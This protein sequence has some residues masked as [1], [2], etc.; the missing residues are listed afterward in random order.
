MRTR[1]SY[2]TFYLCIW[3]VIVLN[4]LED[5]RYNLVIN[6]NGNYNE[7]LFF[8][9][10][11][12]A[13][14]SSSTEGSSIHHNRRNN[15]QRGHGQRGNHGHGHNNNNNNFLYN[16]SSGIYILQP[17]PEMQEVPL[18][19]GDIAMPFKSYFA[20][21]GAPTD[22][23]RWNQALMQAARGEQVLLSRVMNVIKSPLDLFE[24]DKEFKWLHK[25]ADYH[26][27][28]KDNWLEGMDSKFRAPVVMLGYRRFDR[29]NYE[30]KQEGAESMGPDQIIRKE[31]AFKI[32]RK[33]VA[34]GNM[35][36]NWG[37]LSTYFLNR[38]VPW[39]LTFAG[40]E[41]PMHTKFKFPQEHMQFMLDDPNLIMMVVSQHHNISHP[42]VISLP[43][44]LIEAKDMWYAMNNA[45]RSGTKKEN[46]L[47][48]A[49]SNYA[50]RTKIRKC[51]ADNLG[52]A[53]TMTTSKVAKDAYRMKLIG[54]AASLCMPGL[55]YDSYRLWETLAS[56]SMAVVERGMGMD[57]SLYKLPVLLLDDFAALTGSIL[58]QAYVE[59]LY[60]ADRWE[61]ERMTR[62]WWEQ[63]M[64]TVS[65]ASDIAPLLEKHP[66]HA[67]DVNFTR[68]LVPFDCEK[69]GGCGVGTKRVP[70]VSCAIDPSVMNYNYNWRWRHDENSAR[71]H[72]RRQLR[73]GKNEMV[74]SNAEIGIDSEESMRAIGSDFIDMEE[75]NDRNGEIEITSFVQ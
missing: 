48:S 32:P 75:E 50:Y 15:P 1:A 41:N 5:L 53:F 52:S 23:L 72:R 66:M 34:V 17:S 54:S 46:L 56:G 3:V 38:T 19:W 35:D 11:V 12:S 16:N 42:K 14:S 60:L 39:A 30:G 18:P 37:W 44:G 68:P 4:V 33:I 63:L 49:G 8:Y 61:Y 51:V 13:Q 7:K 73:E 58:R 28:T 20:G 2:S 45:V 74:D 25:L 6:S 9:T 47:F 69:I 10:M 55:G 36:E 64:F 71:R 70:K 65:E 43:L 40:E 31:P 27:S 26:R 22:A 57:R 62:R 24:G 29:W 67:E 59:A 21:F